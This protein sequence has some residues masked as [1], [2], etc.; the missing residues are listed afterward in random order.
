MKLKYRIPLIA[1]SVLIAWVI[2]RGMS[3]WFKMVFGMGLPIWLTIAYL[4]FIAV[5][6]IYITSSANL[7]V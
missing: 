6:S 5:W 1:V 2:E 3:E 7:G 4:L